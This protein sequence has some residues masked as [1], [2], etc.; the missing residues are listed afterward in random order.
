MKEPMRKMYHLLYGRPDKAKMISRAIS[1][2]KKGKSGINSLSSSDA[3]S[4]AYWL[5]GR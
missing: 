2:V 1:H 3:I 5:C 4:N